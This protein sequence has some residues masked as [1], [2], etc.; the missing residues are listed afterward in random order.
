[1]TIAGQGKDKDRAEDNSQ[2]KDRD[3]G[4]NVDRI[5]IQVKWTNNCVR[6][7]GKRQNGG[8]TSPL[9]YTFSPSTQRC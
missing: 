9:M 1:V 2:D 7:K 8:R 3:R 4:E 5:F 6:R